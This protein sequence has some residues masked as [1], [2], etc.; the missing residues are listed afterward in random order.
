MPQNKTLDKLVKAASQRT[1]K[2][3]KFGTLSYGSAYIGKREAKALLDVNMSSN[4][5]VGSTNLTKIQ[6][7]MASGRFNPL[8]GQ[9][10]VISKN[11]VTGEI[12]LVDGQHRLNA[13]IS[14]DSRYPMKLDLLH[15][16]DDYDTVHSTQDSGKSKTFKDRLKMSGRVPKLSETITAGYGYTHYKGNVTQIQMTHSQGFS[17]Y[18]LHAAELAPFHKRMHSAGIKPTKNDRSVTTLGFDSAIYFCLHMIYKNN[19]QLGK[20]F[21]A[22]LTC[23]DRDQWDAVTS[24]RMTR[25]QKQLIKKL[26]WLF[27]GVDRG[28]DKCLL[29]CDNPKI[30]FSSDTRVKRLGRTIFLAHVFTEYFKPNKAGLTD[31]QIVK[32]MNEYKVFTSWPNLGKFAIA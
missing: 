19:G 10:I 2:D 1:I 22:A 12:R 26:Q 30:Q 29:K 24:T 32:T 4:R 28:Y 17:V 6:S 13:I 16:A 11:P 20:D 21:V 25:A 31:A 8:N 27:N 18:D 7:D 15:K 3:P 9:S 14:T 5:R 23:Y